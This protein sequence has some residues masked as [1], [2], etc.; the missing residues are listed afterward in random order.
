M[1]REPRALPCNVKARLRSAATNAV[2]ETTGDNVIVFHPESRGRAPRYL[3]LRENAL[4]RSR[5]SS[6]MSRPITVDRLTCRPRTRATDRLLGS[7]ATVQYDTKHDGDDQCL[8]CLS[9]FVMGAQLKAFPCLHRFCAAC[10]DTWVLH[11]PSCPT[12]RT[13]IN[14]T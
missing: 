9:E 8:I 10:A 2:L 14:T 3:V 6:P 13:P 12:C 11:R 4:T 1:P 7:L 5:S